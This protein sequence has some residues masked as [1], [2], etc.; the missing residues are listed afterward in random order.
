MGSLSKISKRYREQ[1]RSPNL[2]VEQLS[3][4]MDQF[5]CDA[6]SPNY[7]SLDWPR[8]DSY[9]CCKHTSDFCL[10][11]VTHV[12]AKMSLTDFLGHTPFLLRHSGSY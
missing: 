2:T 12:Y 1:I 11:Y 3:G 9:G 8:E 4:V 7:A 5:V 10:M 6:S